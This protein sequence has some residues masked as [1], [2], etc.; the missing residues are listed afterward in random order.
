MRNEPES[1]EA[2]LR[3]GAAIFNTGEFHAAHD[4]WEHRW[5]DLE[6]GSEDERFLHG[7]IQYTAAVH[8]AFDGNRE[9][10]NGLSD[11]AIRYLRGLPTPYRGVA[12]EPLRYALSAIG[13]DHRVVQR[14]G[15]IPI[16][17]EG[18]PIAANDL[19]A[20][21]LGLAV[22]IVGADNQSYPREFLDEAV[23]RA[24]STSKYRTI[25]VDY[26]ENPQRRSIISERLAAHLDRAQSKD[27]DV[28]G[29]FESNRDD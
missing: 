23:D 3:I 22:K 12:I 19:P 26:L 20:V 14:R 24:E 6:H 5:L 4:A 25:L 28:A 21:E 1:I 10:A 29:L 13:V 8:H 16:I 11:S 9:G 15:V 7:L 17:L 27:D 18:E 2:A